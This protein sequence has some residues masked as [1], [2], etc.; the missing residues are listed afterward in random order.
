MQHLLQWFPPPYARVRSLSLSF[1]YLP[2]H[3]KLTFTSILSLQMY[4]RQRPKTEKL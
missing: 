3:L 2:F 1:L 4:A